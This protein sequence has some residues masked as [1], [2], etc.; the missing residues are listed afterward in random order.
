MSRRADRAFS[1]A[2]ASS[3]Y[4]S[5]NPANLDVPAPA[6]ASAGVDDIKRIIAAWEKKDY[7]GLLQLPAPTVD[8]L[9]RCNMKV[10]MEALPH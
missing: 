9:G 2:C 8:D 4:D 6:P 7:F 10:S 3:L 5:Q 1:Q